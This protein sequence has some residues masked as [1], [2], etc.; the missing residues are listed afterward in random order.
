M[1]EETSNLV[2]FPCHHEREENLVADKGGLR[3]FAEALHKNVSG[4]VRASGRP[5]I[6]SDSSLGREAFATQ[7]V[8]RT[9]ERVDIWR[10]P[11]AVRFTDYISFALIPAVNCWAIVS[12][13]RGLVEL[14][15]VHS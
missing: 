4:P 14:L 13:R 2:L 8:K 12:R 6:A 11:S 7:S 10:P 1:T 5:T 9:T 15:F 3:T